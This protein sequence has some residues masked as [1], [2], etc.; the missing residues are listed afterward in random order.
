MKNKIIYFLLIVIA[1]EGLVIAFSPR[2]NLSN[3]RNDSGWDTDY[4]GG[5]SGGWD[6]GGWDSGSGG[7]YSWGE[8]SDYDEDDDVFSGK[9]S[10]FVITMCIGTAFIV[11]LIII[12]YLKTNKYVEENVDDSID[13]YNDV[14]DEY[15]LSLLGIKSLDELKEELFKIFVDIQNAWMEFDYKALSK[16]CGD[17]LYNSYKSDLEVL[18][19]KNGK[20]IMNSFNMNKMS[21]Y[22]YINETNYIDLYVN[23]SASFYDY[24]ID[25][26]NDKVIRG[27]KNNILTNNYI[28]VYRKY[29]TILDTCPSCGAP[30]SNKSNQKCEHCGSKIVNNNDNYILIRKGRS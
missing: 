26:T 3:V 17:E 7:S 29:K 10:T 28:L 21:I 25:T 13:N 30:I 6:S 16:L 4:G 1:I 8:Y 15:L 22:N 23:L 27:N 24:V 18:K 2:F 12:L 11:F 9:V 19:L 20:N 5:S 14:D